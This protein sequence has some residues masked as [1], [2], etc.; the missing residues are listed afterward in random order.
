MKAH[1]NIKPIL[2]V[3]TG[4]NPARQFE[5]G[6]QRGGKYSCVCG[7]PA[8]EHSNFICCYNTETQT[9]EERRKLVVSGNA[10]HKMKTGTVNP[11]QNLRKEEIIAEL[12]SRSI[13]PEVET[14]S[15]VQE[16]LASVLH[17]V[18]RPPALC[19]EDP[20]RT[21]KDLNIDDYEVLACEPLHD[22]TNVIQN[23]IQ[24]LP[25]HVPDDTKQEFQAFSETTIGQ[26]NQIKGSDARLY[27]VKLAKFTSQKFEEGKVEENI[28]DLVNALVD[29][30]TVCYSNHTARSQKQLLR[31][32]NQCFLFGILCKIVVGNP[33]KL[34]S[35][36]FYGN[37]FHSITVH[38]PETARLFNLKSII[39]E[40]EERS[41]GTL[42]RISENTT[43]R[44]SKYIVDNAVLR[45]NFQ[46][47][48]NDP[49]ETISKQ[50]STIS[51]Q[52]KLLPA[53]KPTT[54]TMQL[55]QR[56]PSLVQSHFQRIADYI[57]LGEDV[58]WC[59]DSQKMVFH[60]GPG[61]E[62]NRS[63]GPHLRHFRSASL[64]QERQRIQEIWERCVEVYAK[65]QLLLP[66][67][68]LKTYKDGKVVY[69]YPNTEGKKFMKCFNVKLKKLD[70]SGHECPI[71]EIFRFLKV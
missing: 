29:I 54:L 37:H 4:D 12:E 36:K 16:K 65:G 53:R 24:E 46:T 48:K 8:T 26:K 7:V 13:W 50:N 59:V 63:L 17:G 68:G 1:L 6:Q 62:D 42:G 25:H 47:L 49:T 58:W 31:L 9:L 71:D 22:L 52:A 11:F 30:I 43:N 35:R 45:Y 69:I 18:V 44:Q 66:L 3:F 20:T 40:Q 57:I 51:K 15:E 14:K 34:T 2:R 60:D 41:F 67:K 19:C 23:L 61:D 5:S 55:I 70:V 39:P 32:Y 38:V 21:V 28:L 64:K 33:K 56:Y 27:A 10:W